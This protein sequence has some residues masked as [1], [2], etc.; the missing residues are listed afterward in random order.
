MHGLAGLFG[1]DYW[2]ITWADKKS[3]N[4]G[5]QHRARSTQR[6]LS[7]R[8]VQH[9][10]RPDL[11]IEVLQWRAGVFSGVSEQR[12]DV[13][14]PTG[15]EVRLQSTSFVLP[16]TS[17]RY[18]ASCDN[19]FQYSIRHLHPQLGID[20]VPLFRETNLCAQNILRCSVLRSFL[21]A[22]CP[23][24]H[25]SHV[26]PLISL[27]YHPP[28]RGTCGT[29]PYLDCAPALQLASL[30]IFPALVISSL[31]R[32]FAQDFRSCHKP[33][34]LLSAT[35]PPSNTER[36]YAEH[37]KLT[38]HP[39]IHP[40]RACPVPD[41]LSSSSN[42]LDPP[43]LLLVVRVVLVGVRAGAASARVRC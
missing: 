30:L 34:V 22:S 23:Q 43:Y 28:P 39:H 27:R 4:F 31:D 33:V 21:S 5:A 13:V 29:T 15:P 40:D 16:T 26:H 38:S 19:D 24:L 3:R 10:R 17:T 32:L 35:L 42:S 6:A 18:R 2:R 37:D 36:S 8:S 12:T 9:G 25:V 11:V 14:P 1:L 7:R 41:P 20:T